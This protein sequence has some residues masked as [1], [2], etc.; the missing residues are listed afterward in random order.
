MNKLINISQLSKI[1][2][3]VNPLNLKPQNHILRYWESQ[4]KQI[5]PKIINKRRYYSIEQVETI[6]MIKFLLK[7]KGMTISGAK[8]ILNI[9]INKLDDYNSHGLKVEYYKKSF[10]NKSKT[11]LGKIKKLKKYGKKNTFKS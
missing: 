10:K 2:N 3:L 9:E 8:N 7:D 6:K 5:R 11:L 4:F 1:L